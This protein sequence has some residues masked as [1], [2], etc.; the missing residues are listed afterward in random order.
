MDFMD[1]AVTTTSS[2]GIE[3]GLDVIGILAGGIHDNRKFQ[4]IFLEAGAEVAAYEKDNTEECEVRQIIFCKD[5]MLKLAKGMKKISGFE[6]GKQ[7]DIY[8]D[9]LLRESALTTEQKRSCKI[10]F[11]EVIKNEIMYFFGEIYQQNLIGET[12]SE[13]KGMR[14]DLKKVVN[15]LEEERLEQGN[16]E[17]QEYS[18]RPGRYLLLD[19]NVVQQK[20]IIWKLSRYHSHKVFKSEEERKKEILY[21]TDLWKNERE[22]YPDWYIP[23]YHI[24]FELKWSFEENLLLQPTEEISIEEL[25]EFAYELVWRYETGMKLYESYERLRLRAIWDGY[26]LGIDD[27][28]KQ[29]EQVEDKQA[30]IIK[31]HIMHWFYIG[32]ALLRE[33]REEGMHEEWQELYKELEPYREYGLNGISELQIEKIKFHFMNFEFR[34][35]KRILDKWNIPSE[36]YEIRLQVAGIWAELGNVETALQRLRE[37]GECIDHKLSEIEDE[38]INQKER[39]HLHSL[40]AGMLRVISIVLQGY[41]VWKGEFEKYQETINQILEMIEKNREYFDWQMTLEEIKTEMLMWYVRR[42]KQGEPFE[43][44]R[45]NIIIFGGGEIC[46]DVYRLYRILDKLALPLQCN[47]VTLM[48]NIEFPWIEALMEIKYQL[49]VNVLIRGANSKNVKDIINRN[50]LAGCNQDIIN[51]TI[52]F[53]KDVLENNLEEIGEC[54]VW[55][56][57]NIYTCIVEHVP[58]ML[59]RYLSRC[60]ESLQPDVMML[61]KKMT[62]MPGFDLKCH[63]DE[64][65]AD[66]MRCISRETKLKMLGTMLECGMYER[67]EDHGNA[68]AFDVFD[69]YATGGKRKQ[70]VNIGQIVSKKQVEKLLEKAKHSEYER[71]MVIPRLQT[72]YDLGILNEEQQDFFGELLWEHIRNDI[73]M[74]DYPKLYLW[75]Y[76]TL[77]HPDGIEPEINLKKYFLTTDLSTIQNTKTK[78]ISFYLTELEQS[79]RGC[80]RDFW[81]PSEIE[82]LLQKLKE[83]WDGA[84]E[85]YK[86]THIRIGRIGHSDN[87]K[88]VVKVCTALCSNLPREYSEKVYM[89]MKT[90]ISEMRELGF[91]TLCLDILFSFKAELTE[92]VNR[93][94]DNL[95]STEKGVTIDAL[96]ATYIC[97]LRNSEYKLSDR[98]LY[99]LANMVKTRKE[100]GLASVLTTLH[101]ILY[102]DLVPF[103]NQLKIILDKALLKIED[104][105]EYQNWV[106]SEKEMKERI[107][108]RRACASLA[109]QLSLHCESEEEFEGIKCWHDVCDGDEFIEVKAAW[110]Y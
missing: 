99:E 57:G 46:E 105:T 19:E 54:N 90:T 48:N 43:I 109:K 41:A 2:Y 50:F 67:K 61:L 9:D 10:H 21:I 98:L 33:Y 108:I 107:C 56:E 51:N 6:W 72:L 5:N 59:T 89:Q 23:P 75:V 25:L 4:D 52:I 103:S 63:M 62:N 12:A 24:C 82:K 85:E 14:Q 49:A 53:L 79:I 11:V 77:P 31:E 44:N 110:E 96:N 16:R 22:S 100:P 91:D 87:L 34:S 97:I 69:F 58:N 1:L 65:T 30:D 26:R 86:K 71:R 35:V 73:N 74:P 29:I 17:M 55:G 104:Q 28:I 20:K 40:K 92:V 32:Q 70:D 3:K 64:F 95:Y 101:N 45:E 88:T 76:T 39:L 94:I 15:L 84:K 60:P 81:N 7:L 102:E 37:L 38:E 80:G 83:Y 66:L 36:Q 27:L 18:S 68:A 93:L 78:S 13:V 106:G 42:Y 47:H 8:L